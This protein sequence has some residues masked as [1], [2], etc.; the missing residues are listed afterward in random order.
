[1]AENNP[2]GVPGYGSG[3]TAVLDEDLT[4]V[5][6]R[7]TG[8]PRVDPSTTMDPVDVVVE[9]VLRDWIINGPFGNVVVQPGGETV[10]QNQEFTLGTAVRPWGAIY[11]ELGVVETSDARA[12]SYV[13]DSHL[14]RDFIM[15]LRPVSYTLRK[16]PSSTSS[17]GFIGQEVEKALNGFAFGGLVKS[18]DTYALRYTHFIA[19]LVKCV[20]EQQAQ[21]ERMDAE[22]R[23]LKVAVAR[24]KNQG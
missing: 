7:V 24:L 22:L 8:D 4:G 12:K 17:C 9:D 18:D 23:D 1:M 10:V 16:Q 13:V 11:A 15:R 14:G 20:Q 5:M 2:G 19:P 3:M 6:D 21:I